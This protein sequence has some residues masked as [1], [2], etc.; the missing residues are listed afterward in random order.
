MRPFAFLIHHYSLSTHRSA[1]FM[2][3]IGI[4]LAGTGIGNDPAGDG[5]SR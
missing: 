4:T 2:P 1:D 3:G 5:I